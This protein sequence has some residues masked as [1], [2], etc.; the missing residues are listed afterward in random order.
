MNETR[1][2]ATG[3]ALS[4]ACVDLQQTIQLAIARALRSLNPGLEII[5]DSVLLTSRF[6]LAW[7][8]S[9]AVAINPQILPFSV[10]L[11][12][13]FLFAWQYFAV[14]AINSQILPFS[15]QSL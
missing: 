1:I 5:V 13:R 3:R 9:A 4:R 6:L 15:V 10:L 12:S 2:G 7:Q 14:V 11:T 8:E